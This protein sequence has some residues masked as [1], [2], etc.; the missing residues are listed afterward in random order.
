MQVGAMGM[1]DTYEAAAGKRTIYAGKQEDYEELEDSP[2][3][4]V[5]T[6]PEAATE[7]SARAAFVSYLAILGLGACPSGAAHRS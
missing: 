6:R 5:Y 4:P 2:W 3:A 1:Q 7:A